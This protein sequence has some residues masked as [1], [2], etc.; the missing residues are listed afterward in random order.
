MIFYILYS[1]SS[2]S[3][4]GLVNKCAN[5]RF[6]CWWLALQGWCHELKDVDGE[7]AG[8]CSQSCGSCPHQY[9]TFK[10]SHCYRPSLGHFKHKSFSSYA[11]AETKCNENPFCRGFYDQCG[12]GKKFWICD[13]AYSLNWLYL[14]E[15]GSIT[16]DFMIDNCGN[17]T[18]Y[19]KW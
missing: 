17:S 5:K 8:L 1:I 4:Q 18:L 6:D 19:I 13:M 16:P 7:R 3:K 15:Y 14:M 11:E 10:N 9:K 2:K 12:N